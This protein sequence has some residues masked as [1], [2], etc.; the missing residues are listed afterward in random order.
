MSNPEVEPPELVTTLLLVP[1]RPLSPFLP[2]ERAI[3]VLLRVAVLRSPP[4]AVSFGC[5]TGFVQKN[6][7]RL[8]HCLVPVLPGLPSLC[9]GPP[10]FHPCLQC[11]PAGCHLLLR[12][13]TSPD[14]GS[15]I[16]PDI[17]TSIIEGDQGARSAGYALQNHP[18]T[19]A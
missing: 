1:D 6:D 12:R 2:I 4:S 8:L 14:S 17:F 9:Q 5:A 18:K 11:G 10:Q 15:A 3:G 13:R 19:L 7:S 16:I